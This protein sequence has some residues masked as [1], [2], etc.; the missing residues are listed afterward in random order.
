MIYMRNNIR[1]WKMTYQNTEDGMDVL[2]SLTQNQIISATKNCLTSYL[3][4]L[5]LGYKI[6]MHLIKLYCQRKIPWL[7]LSPFIAIIYRSR[8]DLLTAS[9]VRTGLINERFS[10]RPILVCPYIGVYKRTFAYELVFA[11]PALPTP[12]MSCLFYLDKIMRW[13][14]II[15]ICLKLLL[16]WRY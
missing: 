4:R 5:I 11:S 3:S 8:W 2:S 9:S 12:R 13:E 6:Y 16:S 1:F 14:H 15:S 7:S 10:S